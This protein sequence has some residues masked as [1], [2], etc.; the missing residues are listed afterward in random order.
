MTP[1]REHAGG[2][3]HDHPG[4]EPG[5]PRAAAGRRAPLE[6]HVSGDDPALT[7][8]ARPTSTVRATWTVETS[9]PAT[10]GTYDFEAE[11]VVRSSV[12]GG[13]RPA[14]GTL[15][16]V[17]RDVR[18]RSASW[19]RSRPSSTSPRVRPGTTSSSAPS[20]AS[21]TAAP[22]CS[23]RPGPSPPSRPDLVRPRPP[24]VR[25]AWTTSS[26]AWCPVP[27]DTAPGPLPGG[28]VVPRRRRQLAADP[29]VLGYTVLAP[30][31]VAVA[32]GSGLHRLS[33]PARSGCRL[34]RPARRSGTRRLRVL[35]A[36]GLGL[37]LAQPEC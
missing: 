24:A 22:R 9:A 11:C 20:P 8:T 36:A 28:G 10:V 2:S 25:R 27:A 1:D 16:R 35:I 32:G 37:A 6:W 23:C 17:H 33:R 5:R 14:P 7:S 31:A 30:G 13:S 4:D 3:G 19:I 29:V 12:R 18:G 21:V 26:A 15:R 34:G